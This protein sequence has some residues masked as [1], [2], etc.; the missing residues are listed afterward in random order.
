MPDERVTEATPVAVSM[1][2]I[3]KR[4][5]PRGKLL[6]IHL[7]QRPLIPADEFLLLGAQV[8]SPPG[9]CLHLIED[10]WSQPLA[11]QCGQTLLFLSHGAAAVLQL[12]EQLA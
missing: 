5:L 6:L 1:H 8:V 4:N 3:G 9:Q 11:N 10:V 12:W 7:R 2:L